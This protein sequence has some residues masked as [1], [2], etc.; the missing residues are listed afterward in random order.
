MVQE[1]APDFVIFDVGCGSARDSLF[2]SLYGFDVVGFDGC[3]SAVKLAEGKAK[4]LGQTSVTFRESMTSGSEIYGAIDQQKDK[5]I[6]VYARFFLHAINDAEQ[7]HFFEQLA[8][9]LKVGDMLAFEYRNDHDKGIPKIAEPHYRRYQ[10][11]VQVNTQLE[12]LGFETI[13]AIDGKGFAKY[14]TEDAEVSRGIFK[15]L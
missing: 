14:K 4:F 11:S 6:C 15:K 9:H 12:T 2:F 8:A 7:S 10:P 1:L 3:P 5:N 13:Y